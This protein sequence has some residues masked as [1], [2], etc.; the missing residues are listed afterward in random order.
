MGQGCAPNDDYDTAL[1]DPDTLKCPPTARANPSNWTHLLRDDHRRASPEDHA[2]GP[3]VVALDGDRRSYSDEFQA[4]KGG[5]D[6][7]PTIFSGRNDIKQVEVLTY[8]KRVW[9][10]FSSTVNVEGQGVLS[11]DVESCNS[12]TCVGSLDDGGVPSPVSPSPPPSPQYE[13]GIT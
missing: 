3:A 10:G 1:R 13:C 11:I 8:Q 2:A 4:G 12:E 5:E 7:V 9:G 6:L